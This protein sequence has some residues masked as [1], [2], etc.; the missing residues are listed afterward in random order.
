MNKTN[1]MRMLLFLVFFFGKMGFGFAQNVNA[2][3]EVT[4][5][6][7]I[8][9]DEA[10]ALF[11]KK[12]MEL[13]DKFFHTPVDTFSSNNYYR[14]ELIGHYLF[15]K[16]IGSQLHVDL[17]NYNSIHAI[18]LN[19]QRDLALQ[20]IDSL[21]IKIEHAQILLGKKEIPFDQK[22]KSYRKRKK[23][24]GGFLTIKANGETLFYRL[25][26][27]DNTPIF[28]KK[29]QRFRSTKI[30][31]ILIPPYYL[32]KS[33]A[34]KGYIALNKPKFLPGD[35][36]KV[37]A[38][39]T[40]HK[41]KPFK[42]KLQ[43]NLVDGDSYHKT[44]L[45]K[46]ELSPTTPGAYLYQFVLSDSLNL[47]SY[48]YLNFSYAKRKKNN[49]KVMSHYFYYEDYQ[50]DEVDYFFR[51]KQDEYSKGESII[52]FAEG[53]DKNGWTVPHGKVNLIATRGDVDEFYTKEISI[54][55]TLWEHIQYLDSRGETQILFPQNILPEVKMDI[56]IEA[57]FSN[58]NGELQTENLEFIYDALEEKIIAKIENGFVVAEYFLNGK[59]VEKEVELWKDNDEQ[60]DQESIVKLP[61]KER[62]N[63]FCNYYSFDTD[64]A[65]AELEFENYGYRSDPLDIKPDI[66][67]LGNRTPDSIFTTII[68][69]HRIPIN[70]QIRTKN[71]I[72]TEGVTEEK[73]WNYQLRKTGGAPFFVY[74]QYVWGGKPY[75]KE[76]TYFHVSKLLTIKTDQPS[77][78]EPGEQIQ[79]KV[80]VKDQ[81]EKPRKNV[82]LAAGAI[83]AQFEI[84]EN[85]LE[86]TVN[87]KRPRKPRLYNS[88]KLAKIKSISKTLNLSTKWYD[89]L[90]LSESLFYRLRYPKDGFHMESDSITA[91]TFYRDIPQ[92]APY[93]VKDGKDVPI[94]LIYCNRQLVYYYGVNDAP[95]YSFVG[96]EGMNQIV[97]RGRDFTYTVDSVF[98]KAGHKLEFSIDVDNFAKSSFSKNIKIQPANPEL[99]HQEKGLLQRKILHIRNYNSKQKNYVWQG[100]WNI[101]QLPSNFRYIA[102]VGPF[103][104]MPIQFLERDGWNNQFAFEP[105]YTHVVLKGRERLYQHDFFPFK[106]KMVLPEKIAAQYPGKIIYSPKQIEVKSPFI[107]KLGSFK[108][109]SSS[110]NNKGG[111]YQFKIKKGK[112]VG[113]YKFAIVLLED[114]TTFTVYNNYTDEIHNLEP[115]KYTLIV[116]SSTGNYIKKEFTIQRDTLLYHDLSDEIITIDSSQLLFN[117][118]FTT[119]LAQYQKENG[120]TFSPPPTTIP[121]YDYLGDIGIRGKIS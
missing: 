42:K 29:W 70:Y 61:Y 77:T 88:F 89:N 91:D 62:I 121:R 82:N 105:G 7:K 112:E 104:Q 96:Q 67:L 71:N 118:I 111:T 57:Q 97:I 43:L 100:T 21:G 8:T 44:S 59:S 73:I 27:K 54:P 86:P 101:H 18:A 14:T 60:I 51:S 115:K 3:S 52:F 58:S 41:G 24:T 33:K 4:S 39:F 102:T 103:L 36:V 16:A 20:V 30:G 53:K 75:E 116:F 11:H 19:N 9:D 69:P 1:D 108:S 81:N 72:L 92:F 40:N 2:F 50:L 23:Y 117:K 87:H 63:P 13:T 119:Y 98:L 68:N 55:D 10:E 99:S 46:V 15:V 35:T 28:S 56:N 34:T 38:Y 64:K 113:F 31:R 37:K 12:D 90:Q 76:A 84:L 65:G 45:H 49:I 74:F 109:S 25:N 26:R 83:N 106:K 79:V 120:K 5:I 95:P 47:D 110:N 32:N 78:V 48:Y 66:N 93:L 6:Y 107:E 22:T 80:T 114:D 94:Y 85:V 17:K